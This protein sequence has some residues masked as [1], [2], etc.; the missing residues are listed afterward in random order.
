MISLVYVEDHV[1]TESLIVRKSS[2]TRSLEA[3]LLDNVF[4]ERYM[5]GLL[6]REAVP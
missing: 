4:K 5:K 6:H 3:L 2:V 1:L